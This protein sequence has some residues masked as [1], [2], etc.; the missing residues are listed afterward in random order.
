MT[1]RESVGAAGRALRV[2]RLASMGLRLPS[3]AV[4]VM[5]FTLA[6]A[7]ATVLLGPTAVRVTG[8]AGLVAVAVGVLVH[9]RVVDRGVLDPL[10]VMGVGIA[11]LALT[12]VGTAGG[13]RVT[14]ATAAVLIA[15]P[16]LGR[17]LLRLFA[18]RLSGRNSDVLVQAGLAAL[19]VGV[20]LSILTTGTRVPAPH[21]LL[22]IVAA[23][24]D[25]ALLTVAVR[26]LLLPGERVLT[27]RCLVVAFGCLLCAHLAAV[28]ALVWG[29]GGVRPVV[30]LLATAPFLLFGA[31]ALHPSVKRLDDPID[32]DPPTFS[33][34]HVAAVVVAMLIGPAAVAVHVV[35]HQS[36]SRTTA[37]GAALVALMLAAYVGSLLE[38]RAEAEHRVQH[39]ELTGLPNRALLT[40]RISRALAHARRSGTSVGVMFIDLDR[41]KW[42]NDTF[43]HGTG[44]LLLR[45]VGERLQMLLRD[46]DTVARLSGDEFAVLLPHVS[47][48]DGAV[49]VAER[50]RD[51]FREPLAIGGER[52][53]VTASIGVAL[54]PYDGEE[55]EELITCADAAMYRAKEAGRRRVRHLQRGAGDPGAGTPRPRGVAA[56]RH[57]ARRAR[58]ALPTDLRRSRRRRWSAPRRSCAGSI[59]S[60]ASSCRGDSCRSLSSPTSSSRWVRWSSPP[61]AVR[62]RRGRV[63]ACRRS[64]SPSTCPP[65]QLRAGMADVVAANLRL[66]GID[67]GR[68]VLELTE[69]A[70]V[71]DVDRV[72]ATLAEV[73]NMGVR[74]AIDDFGTGY[75][76]LMYLS[77]LP[78]DSLKIDKSFV[79]SASP[80][81]ESIV[82]AIIAMGHGLG[83]T[84]VAE[85]VE[86]PEQLK[87]LSAKGCDR[88]QG[89]LFGRPLPP[90]EFERFVRRTFADAAAAA[91][92]GP[93]ALSGMR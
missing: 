90:L 40:D 21:L 26:L 30:T 8:A 44:D 92:S 15:Y 76:S 75:C 50:V 10:L 55:P 16:P 14:W 80:A 58:P 35:R 49:T 84:V 87:S 2:P 24:L 23:S 71:D 91:P 51:L 27:Y 48:P 88:V 33:P 60:V 86:R 70:A 68:L 93:G 47:G 69:T 41:F 83:M 78:V 36:V 64:A 81:D 11:V 66:T 9:R 62:W 56:R 57:G 31:A 52:L 74:W 72:A 34:A 18:A 32:G 37:I 5:A 22:A 20:T 29:H 65:R 6:A 45:L 61:R 59:P 4:P 43:G 79:Q 19:A 67:P 3:G 85:G 63:G 42:V 38:D 7:G 39:D 46:E 28:T 13:S 17:G 12:G 77:R 73:G 1:T 82:A 25:A 53:C 89:F 54:Y